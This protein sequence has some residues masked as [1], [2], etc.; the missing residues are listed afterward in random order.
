MS[1]YQTFGLFILP[2]NILFVVYTPLLK[3]YAPSW[4]LID[5][6]SDRRIHSKEIPRCG[7]PDIIICAPQIIID[8]S[9]TKLGSDIFNCEITDYKKIITS[10][11]L[12]DI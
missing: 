3:F 9:P 6:P 8:G 12:K 2:L 7:G 5:K 11:I 10:W 1:V 4:G